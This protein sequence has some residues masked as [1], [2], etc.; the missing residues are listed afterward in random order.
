MDYTE[1]KEIWKVHATTLHKHYF[2]AYFYQ[3]KKE[4]NV[5]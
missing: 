5:V 3:I 4:T 2:E 1:S